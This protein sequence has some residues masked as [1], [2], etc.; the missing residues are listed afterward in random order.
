LRLNSQFENK[1]FETRRTKI[2][3][4]L[5]KATRN[6]ASGLKV[7]SAADDPAGLEVSETTRAQ[8][9]GLGQ[10]QR[11]IQDS[12]ALLKTAEDG[13]MKTNE[14]V[15]RLHELSV[16][17]S[18]DTM[19]DES[20]TGIQVEV[21][22]LL[23]SIQETANSVQF[24]TLNL[25]SSGLDNS[26]LNIQLGADSKESMKIELIDLT[27]EKLGLS[28]ASVVPKENALKLIKSTQN[29]ITTLTGHLSKLGAQSSA[30][31][32]NLNNS[33]TLQ[34]NLTTIE[35]NIRDS[36]IGKEVMNLAIDNMLN[37]VNQ[38]LYKYT[39]DQ[40]QHFEKL[41]FG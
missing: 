24:N 20:R 15:Q 31:E 38:T 6:A 25:L 1:F 19:D 27:T 8:I 34:S 4:K 21:K 35:A 3:A 28:N 30:L 10:S 18:S 22:D 33:L 11:N 14:E 16:M 29:A 13:V 17:A 7:I 32:Q 5:Q 23:E 36:D 41:L 26:K 37:D 9:R 40:K 12:M 39:D 2:V